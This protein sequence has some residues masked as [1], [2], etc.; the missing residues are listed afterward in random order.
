M[1]FQDSNADEDVN[2]RIFHSIADVFQKAQVTYAG[3]RKHVAVLKKIQEKAVSQGYE[4]AFNY[5]FNA[6]VSKVLPLRKT[7]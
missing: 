4:A 1:V 3:H 6:V 5:W 7:K 2:T